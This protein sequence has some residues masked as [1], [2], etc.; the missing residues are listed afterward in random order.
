[1]IYLFGIGFVAL[2]L[3]YNIIH[4]FQYKN[5]NY[6]I[7]KVANVYLKS[8]LLIVNITINDDRDGSKRVLVPAGTLLPELGD[9]TVE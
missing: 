3:Q 7:T 4:W 5:E 2:Q 9:V 6:H 8:K 1:M